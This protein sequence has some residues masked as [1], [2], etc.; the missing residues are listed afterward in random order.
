M[1]PLL[2]TGVMLFRAFL[3]H[4]AVLLVG[5]AGLVGLVGFVGCSGDATDHGELTS[6]MRS[7][8][9]TAGARAVCQCAS[10][11]EGTYLCPS[12]G[13]RPRDPQTGVLDC[14]C[15]SAPLKTPGED[16]APNPEPAPTQT[17]AGPNPSPTNRAGDTCASLASFRTLEVTKGAPLSFSMELGGMTDDFKS[18]CTRA[19]GPDRIQ[20]ILA[21]SNGTMT[22]RVQSKSS[23]VGQAVLYA[24]A[25]CDNPVDIACSA[26]SERIDFLVKQGVVYFVHF[27]GIAATQSAEAKVT[28]LAEIQ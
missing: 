20:P 3:G 1:A 28:A 23:Y 11:K 19:N 24:K 25:S 5:L 8:R 17:D 7:D 10:L 14:Q 12:S 26:T 2:L 13:V 21:K 9:C 4:A 6:G 15:E 18:S 16:P 27:D 22:V